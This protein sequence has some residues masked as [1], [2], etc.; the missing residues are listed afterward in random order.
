MLPDSCLLPTSSRCTHT[1][2]CSLSDYT[3][4]WVP[5]PGGKLNIWICRVR[6]LRSDRKRVKR[7]RK[8]NQI[9]EVLN[10]VMAKEGICIH[11]TLHAVSEG[12][13][14]KGTL[15]PQFV[16]SLLIPL[17]VLPS[18]VWVG[19]LGE[20]IR[21]SAATPFCPSWDTALSLSPTSAYRGSDK[22]SKSE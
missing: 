10:Q 7:K 3:D 5:V 16:I 6:A 18:C 13:Q 2:T 9:I 12:V 20:R 14:L 22:R 11:Y 1:H 4:K 17:L 19:L 21:M 8:K 15:I